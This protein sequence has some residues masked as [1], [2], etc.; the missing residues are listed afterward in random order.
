[1][2]INLLPRP[3]FYEKYRLAVLVGAGLLVALI[4]LNAVYAY[5]SLNSKIA[6]ARGELDRIK[7]D[8]IVLSSERA[9]TPEMRR[10][11]EMQTAVETLRKEQH[12]FGRILDGIAAKLSRK[13]RVTAASFD[14]EKQAISLELSS[15]SMDV[16][17][18]YETLLRSEPWVRDLFV[19]K[20][21]NNTFSER[22][23]VAQDKKERPYHATITILLA[24]D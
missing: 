10:L 18:E 16:I 6:Q 4:V 14:A 8:L 12:D 9:M 3:S 7:S 20:I 23:N 21:E 24:R 17:A 19:E 5:T 13:S 15:E 11:Q 1:V 2:E 22:E